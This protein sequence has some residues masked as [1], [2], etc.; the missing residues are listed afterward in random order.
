SRALLESGGLASARLPSLAAADLAGRA[1]GVQRH[2]LGVQGVSLATNSGTHPP[3]HAGP[4]PVLSP[5]QRPFRP[6]HLYAQGRD[7]L[8]QHPAG[9]HAGADD[10]RGSPAKDSDERPAEGSGTG[11]SRRAIDRKSTRLNSSHQIIS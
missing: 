5:H 9:T 6:P 8:A 7:G 3:R 1:D 4:T 11:V 10:P 2:L